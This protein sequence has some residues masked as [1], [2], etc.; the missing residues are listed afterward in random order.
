[1]NLKTGKGCSICGGLLQPSMIHRGF[2]FIGDRLFEIRNYP[3]YICA[4]CGEEH[5]QKETKELFETTLSNNLFE[6]N[7][8]GKVP[9]YDFGMEIN[10]TSQMVH[11][12]FQDGSIYC[13][14]NV[15]FTE[16]ETGIRFKSKTLQHIKELHKKIEKKEVEAVR[17][18]S[19]II[20]YATP[21]K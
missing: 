19:H 3:G 6:P 14:Q 16:E 12:L 11:R 13:I 1:M 5:I 7:F 4:D 21:K 17:H 10:E 15:P 9:V 2:L 18:I 20:V 8:V